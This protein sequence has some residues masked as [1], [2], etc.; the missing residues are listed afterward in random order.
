MH[1][2]VTYLFQPFAVFFAHVKDT[3]KQT[4]TLDCFRD[5]ESLEGFIQTLVQ[6]GLS[7]GTIAQYVDHLI[8]GVRYVMIVDG[9]KD[10]EEEELFIKLCRLREQH[11]RQV[12][13]STAHQSW[14]A[15]DAKRK[16]LEW[17]VCLCIKM[18]LRP[19]ST[20]P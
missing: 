19:F 9:V 10:Y 2:T 8:Y 12:V 17:C 20:P 5:E 1:L 16:W 14:Q 6:K 11:R 15:L 3:L 18:A 7:G 4:P 13:H